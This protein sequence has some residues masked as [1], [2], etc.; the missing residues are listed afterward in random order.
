MKFKI[1]LVVELKLKEK[2]TDILKFEVKINFPVSRKVV[3]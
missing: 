1:K 3:K 2:N